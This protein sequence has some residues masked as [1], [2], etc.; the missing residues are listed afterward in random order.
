VAIATVLSLQLSGMGLASA[1][2]N[3][4]PVSATTVAAAKADADRAQAIADEAAIAAAKALTRLNDAKTQADAEA[5]KAAAAQAKAEQTG[6]AEDIKKAADAAA[7]AATFAAKAAEAQVAYDAAAAKAAATAAA[8]AAAVAH[9]QK[10]ATSLSYVREGTD[11]EG[12]S[13]LVDEPQGLV[14]AVHSDNV[15]VITSVRGRHDANISC[16]VLSSNPVKC[17]SFAAL[18]F[19]HYDKLG[20]DF[21]FAIG[22]AGLSIFSLKDPAHPEWVG[23]VTL[24]DLNAAGNQTMT[25]FWEN[26]N[27]TIDSRR[28]IAW[29]T[30]DSTAA[31][32]LFPVDIRDPWNPKVMG[33]HKVPQGHTATCLNDCR[34][35]WSV[36]GITLPTENP[37]G[38][39]NKASMVAVTDVRDPLHPFTY[40]DAF[41]A[42]VHRSG[43]VTGST[44]SVDVDFDGVAWVS[45][46]RGVRGYWTQ[47]KHY[48][49]VNKVD[50]WA[51][52]YDPISYGGGAV[53]GSDTAFMHNAYR[54]PFALGDQAAGDVMLIGN[55]INNGSCTSAGKFIIASVKGTRD[56][57]DDMGTPSAPAKMD[58]LA[59]Y[60]PGG[61]DGVKTDATGKQIGD[62]SAHWFTVKGNIVAMSF[63]E[64]G[65]RF[66]DISNPRDPQQVGYFR[67]PGIGTGAT[68]QQI[69]TDT[70][71]TYWHGDY[72]YVSD[73]G[74]GI[75]VIKFTGDIPGKQQ[76]KVCWNACDK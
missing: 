64:Q 25:Q 32:G 63:Y 4:D 41:A 18:N 6:K 50:R 16:G 42:N 35:I 30:R 68:P 12:T 22:T 46:S 54:F 19:V 40:G 11:T 45:A 9:Y 44:H 20:Y 3:T 33:F 51:T 47:G 67:V 15:E 53:K 39:R 65:V 60:T 52:P 5:A 27:L 34:Y 75:D 73:Y 66:I 62:C 55:E 74:R 21:M 31:R 59:I 37:D 10:E 71:A 13:T 69:F 72:V 48:D 76:K 29:L 26:E 58:R 14:G 23:Q 49:A 28:M 24:A 2:T 8:A 70:S 57:I 36:G 7:R 56:A 1:G 43:V 17:P 38:F 61:K